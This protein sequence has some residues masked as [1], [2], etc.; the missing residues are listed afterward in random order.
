MTQGYSSAAK[1]LEERARLYG[2]K[3]GSAPMPIS[4]GHSRA[5]K[6]L[7]EEGQFQVYIKGASSHKRHTQWR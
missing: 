1:L 2:L 4:A 7:D 3:G 6:V 5:V